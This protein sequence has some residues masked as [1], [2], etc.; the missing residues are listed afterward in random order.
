MK[1]LSVYS[2]AI[3]LLLAGCGQRQAEVQPEFGHDIYDARCALCH[4][5]NREGR[6]GMYPP[7]A[8]SVF[9]DG[10]PER[11]AAVILDG[12]QGPLDGYNA[13]MP[14]WRD[15]L[16]DSE[17]SAVLT[18][19]READGKQAITPVE[20]NQVRAATQARSTFWNAEDLKNFRMR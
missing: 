4:G 8:G 12:V 9:V 20:V 3:A 11:L 13:V 10:P 14:G 17:I 19:L 16:R 1:A 18:W 7:L 6:P 2:C 5:G 15:Y